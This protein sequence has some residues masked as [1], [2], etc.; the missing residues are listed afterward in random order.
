M[1][2]LWF[3]GACSI[4][5]GGIASFGCII[6]ENNKYLYSA[7]QII[8]IPPNTSSNFAEYA[9]LNHGLRWLIDSGLHTEKV[10]VYGDSKLVINQMFRNLKIK[11]GIYTDMAIATQYLVYAF[12]NI[13]GTWIPRD[14]NTEA[15]KMSRIKVA[16]IEYKQAIT[17]LQQN[18]KDLQFFQPILL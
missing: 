4:N 11:K 12:Q 1:I 7:N 17:H 10:H 18:T 6:K 13:T 8:G 15:D 9:G 16:S 2:E 3:D 5:P 14:Q